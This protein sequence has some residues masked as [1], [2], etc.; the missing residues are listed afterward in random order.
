[1]DIKILKRLGLPKNP[2]FHIAMKNFLVREL[3]YKVAV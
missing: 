2:L 1:M 3:M